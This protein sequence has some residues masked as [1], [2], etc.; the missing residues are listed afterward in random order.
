MK[1]AG[2]TVS[3]ARNASSYYDAV[4]VGGGMVGNAMACSLG[5]NKSFTSKNVLL[6]DAGR[7]PSLSSFESGA[8]FNNRVVAIS[9]TSID[10]FKKLG[11]WERISSHRAKK[12]K[13]LFVFDSC[14][15]SEIEFERGQQEEVAY[16]IEN[17]LIVGSLYEKL[18]EY[19]N[20][21]VK[22]EAKVAE[23]SIPNGLENMATIKLENGNVIETSLLIGADGVNSKVRQ[24]SNLDYST[25]N[26][27]QHGLV[28][29][30]NIETSNGKNETAWQRFTTLGPVALLP[31][32][33]TV[34]GLTWSTS[35][36]EAQRLKQLP[37]D[38][39]V[40]E[41]NHA[42]FS[43]DDQLPY[44]NQAIFA[45]NRMNPFRSETFGRKAE[46][47]TPPHVITVQDKSRAS[48]PLGFGNAHSYITTRC[49]LIGDSAHR[50]HPLAGQGVNLGWSDVQ[51]L[52]KVLGDA[53]REGADIG[54]VTYLREYD[55]AAQKHN[56]PVM[57]SVDL[58]NRLYRTD[59]PA[60]VAVRSLGLNTFNSLGPV[61][62]FLMNYLSAHR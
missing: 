46:G 33:D 19:K 56:L 43:Q 47:T 39:F 48:F 2:G 57:V 25:F 8:P 52:D 51:I 50:M 36:E 27:N 15:T 10:T 44:V 59:A 61:K 18:S 3:C 12:V 38:Q 49:A 6:L 5:A 21:D 26:Y 4:I 60:V 29:I 41:L 55:S 1:L 31:L 9:P 54:S 20:I 30:V 40:D 13:R 35:P 37:P 22:T 32:S 23:C 42:L 62:R 45:L 58:L 16:I 24:S 28:A 34:S 53:V 7:S 11:V 14:S 17:D